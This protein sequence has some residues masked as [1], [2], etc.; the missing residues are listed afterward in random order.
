MQLTVNKPRLSML[1]EV[2]AA[3]VVLSACGGGSGSSSAV[4]DV[5]LS[6]PV[7]GQDEH[8]DAQGKRWYWDGTRWVQGIKPSPS[9]APAPAP[10]PSPAP[11]P[12]P[13]P[14]SWTFC[15]NEYQY[16]SFS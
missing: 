8:V 11:A 12:A 16:C 13:A 15:A 14:T 9:P 6:A 2:M 3:C 1:A 10:A 7:D 4:D 5:L